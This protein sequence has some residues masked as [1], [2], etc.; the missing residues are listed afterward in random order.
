MIS[1][2]Q[3]K[4]DLKI[5]ERVPAYNAGDMNSVAHIYECKEERH[6]W[7]A[8]HVKARKYLPVMPSFA[9]SKTNK[10]GNRL[11]DIS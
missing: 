10:D 3:V 2:T 4:N 11:R 1:L 6:K 8:Y 7:K 9:S 5:A